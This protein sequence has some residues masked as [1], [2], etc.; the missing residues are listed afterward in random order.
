M[1]VLILLFI[2]PELYSLYTQFDIHPEKVVFGRTN[3]SGLKFFFWDSQFGRFFN[4]GPIKG[5][6][7]PTFFLHTTL[8]PFYPGLLFFMWQY[9]IYF[10]NGNMQANKHPY[11][12]LFMEAHLSPFC[13]FHSQAFNCRIT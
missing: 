7:E 3:V 2:T 5:N 4:T 11:E 10:A 6:G 12:G 1:V 13:C 8:W 9:L